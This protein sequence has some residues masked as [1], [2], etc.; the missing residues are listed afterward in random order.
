MKKSFLAT[1]LR[2]LRKN[3]SLTQEE[4]AAYLHIERQ[5]YC[6]Y[7]NDSRTPPLETIIQLADFFRVSVDD[8]VRDDVLPRDTEFL[9]LTQQ[10]QQMLSA[11]RSLSPQARQESLDFI[12]FKSSTR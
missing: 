8:L 10:E 7:E 3:S 6:N 2:T 9:P 5:T 11:F 12:H 1:R 4:V